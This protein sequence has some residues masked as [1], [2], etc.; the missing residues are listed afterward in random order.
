M[1]WSTSNPN[2]VKC[3]TEELINWLGRDWLLTLFVFCVLGFCEEHMI[4]V[5]QIMLFHPW[6]KSFHHSGMNGHHSRLLRLGG[7]FLDGE[8]SILK[9]QISNFDG[10]DFF[11]PTSWEIHQFSQEWVFDRKVRTERFDLTLRKAGGLTWSV[12][13][14]HRGWSERSMDWGSRP[15][16]RS[17]L[18]RHH[19]T[20]SSL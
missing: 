11:H 4:I 17:T 14:T 15:S 12:G 7:G 16:G 8:C 6:G 3:L 2:P 18:S 19:H 10:R 13:L 5:L 20:W 1:S 9:V